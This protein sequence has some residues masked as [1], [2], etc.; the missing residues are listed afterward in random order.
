MSFL[1]YYVVAMIKFLVISKL[2]AEYE[3][4]V[5]IEA[6]SLTD[7]NDKVKILTE[8]ETA[9]NLIYESIILKK[10]SKYNINIVGIQQITS[11]KANK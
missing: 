4:S 10:P 8:K 3:I 6:D 7:V 5:E 11:K 9:E 2:T 1:L